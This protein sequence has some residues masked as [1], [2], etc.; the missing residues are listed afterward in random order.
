MKRYAKI[1][2]VGPVAIAYSTTNL[3]KYI[4]SWTIFGA[5]IGGMLLLS[6]TNYSISRT[7][8]IPDAPH[9]LTMTAEDLVTNVR[10]VGND[11]LD[12]MVLLERLVDRVGDRS[13]G[14]ST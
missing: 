9:Q 5:I 1:F 3:A 2:Q 10:A 7:S 6:L 11:P 14:E 12:P 8:Q 4:A 13:R